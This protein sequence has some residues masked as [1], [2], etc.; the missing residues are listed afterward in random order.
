MHREKDELNAAIGKSYYAN[1]CRKKCPLKNV[2][3]KRVEKVFD[4]VGSLLH[5]TTLYTHI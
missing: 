5:P 3:I 1:M 4:P 2:I